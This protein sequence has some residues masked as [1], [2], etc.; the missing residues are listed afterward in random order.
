MELAGKVGAN[1]ALEGRRNAG[2]RMLPE[3]RDVNEGLGDHIGTS[4]AVE[5]LVAQEGVEGVEEYSKQGG[6]RQMDEIW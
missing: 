4:L 6:T 2:E 3:S 5:L 1:A